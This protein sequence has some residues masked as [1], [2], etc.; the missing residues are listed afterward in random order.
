MAQRILLAAGGTGGHIIPSIAFGRWLRKSGKQVS[1][2]TGSRALENEIFS[3]HGIAPEH[4]SL[5]GSPLGVSGVRSLRRWKQLFSSFFEARHALKA[6]RAEA[7]VLFGG[8]LSMPVLLAAKSLRVPALMHEQNTVAGKVTRLASR[9]GVPVARAWPECRGLDAGVGT[10]VGMPLREIAVKD[11]AEAQKELIG[12][13][14]P[15]GQKLIVILGGSLGSSGMKNMLRSSQNMIESSGCTILCM[16]ITPENRPFSGALT[17]EALWSMTPV[18]SAADAVVCRAGASTLA[19]LEALGVPAIVVPWMKSADGHQLSNAQAFSKRTGCPVLLE[20]DMPCR[21]S[22][23]LSSVGA[24]KKACADLDAGSSNL[25][26][27]L[28]SLTA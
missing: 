16:G 27:V 15:P 10:V 3:A 11:R 21:F 13:V 7:C 4:L 12:R 17:H 28:D 6:G 18:Y 8:Y 19:E 5:E 1:W 22:Q 20:G 9:M 26:K 2:L 23:A 14:L 24:R 25:C